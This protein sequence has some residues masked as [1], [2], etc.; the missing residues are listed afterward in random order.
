MNN[1]YLDHAA[2]TP[3]AKE[4]IEA[5]I[6]VHSQVFGNPSSIHSFGRQARQVMDQAR[7]VFAKSIHADE[8]EIFITSGGTEADN[9]AMIG[10]ALANQQKGNHIITTVQEHHAVLHAAEHLEEIGFEV[11]YLPVYKD[12]KISIG[13][14][15][16][17]LTDS[18]IVVSI[19]AVNNETGITQ[20]IKEIGEL[21]KN[22]QANFHTDAV[23]AYSHLEIDVKRDN[24][25]LL[26]VSSHKVN[27]PKGIGFLYINKNVQVNPLQFG[28]EQERKRRPGTENVGSVAGFQRAVQL[29]MDRK[30]ERNKTYSNYKMIFL[31][32]LKQE[33]LSFEIN[34]AQA[35]LVPSIV[36]ISFPGT[37]VEALLTNFDLSG[38]AASSGSACT[39]GSIEPSH[40]LS[41]MYG[42]EDARTTN[43]I[44]FSFG[45][46]NNQEDIKEAAKRI[47]SI[48][49]RLTV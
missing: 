14:L 24:I 40:V 11:T 22:H 18:T 36:N 27:G 38:V 1:I 28:G 16:N 32:T 13:D 31:D 20:P 45:L 47:A 39:A 19:M 25:D 4:V 26:T 8:K 44:R 41:A 34:G 6:P 17:A 9:L 37:N 12:G 2:T 43:S 3:M 30:D 15:S 21:L 48:V 10:T 42:A 7:V 5:M 35:D 29:L 33:G 23:Q 46:H 49:K